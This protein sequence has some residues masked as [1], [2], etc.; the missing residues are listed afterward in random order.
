MHATCK[1]CFL[2]E[3]MCCEK[4]HESWRSQQMRTSGAGARGVNGQLNALNRILPGRTY[5]VEARLSAQQRQHTRLCFH[6]LQ[7]SVLLAPGLFPA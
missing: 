1:L 2:K 5:A 4:G 3:R 6:Q 7:P